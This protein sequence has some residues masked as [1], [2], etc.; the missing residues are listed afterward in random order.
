MR[1]ARNVRRRAA[2]ARLVLPT[3]LV[4]LAAGAAEAQAQQGKVGAIDLMTT[5]GVEAVKGEWRYHEV[6]TGVGPKKNEIAPRAHG[7]L[8]DSKWDVLKPETLGQPRG[9][10]GYS[11]CWYRIQVTIPEEVNGKPFEG[12]PV[13]F[14]TTVDDYG[15]VWV[16][17]QI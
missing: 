7:K 6:M 1:R 16:D 10:G 3:A 8:D 5:K 11:W 2:V 9:P 17:G 13:W 12:G 14:Q 4:W 15:E